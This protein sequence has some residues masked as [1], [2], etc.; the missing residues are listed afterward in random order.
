MRR[1]GEEREYRVMEYGDLPHARS[2]SLNGE[3]QASCMRAVQP[4]AAKGNE[5]WTYRR[6][7]RRLALFRVNYHLLTGRIL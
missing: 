4:G 6:H 1:E 3:L 5:K 2:L 7:Y